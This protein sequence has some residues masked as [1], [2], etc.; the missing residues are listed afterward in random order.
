MSD[1]LDN[2]DINNPGVRYWINDSPDNSSS[3]N[4]IFLDSSRSTTPDPLVESLK[5][6]ARLGSSSTFGTSCN[7]N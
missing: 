7:K 4:E 2:F 1:D 3:E 5:R 6:V